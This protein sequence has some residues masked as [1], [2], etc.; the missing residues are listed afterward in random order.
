MRS[1]SRVIVLL[2]AIGG[3]FT[4]AFAGGAD[5]FLNA[6]SK[7]EYPVAGK[8]YYARHCFMYEDGTHITTNY[9]RGT[10]VPINSKIKVEVLTSNKLILRVLETGESV[11]V[12]NASKYTKC[13]LRTIARRML[14][15]EPVDLQDF[16]KDIA[17]AIKSG[18]M[19]L[20]MTK[21]QVLM[22][23]GFP[24]AHKTPTLVSDRWQVWPSR[25]VVQTL[26]FSDDKL[27]EARGVD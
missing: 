9:W 13:D 27:I 8:E 22:A 14:A 4:S 21:T 6:I 1:I 25:Y 15:A 18:T 7:E 10:L 23:R 12:D 11:E 5:E 3:L 20:G 19:R 24:P 17:A 16:D 2:L 26:V